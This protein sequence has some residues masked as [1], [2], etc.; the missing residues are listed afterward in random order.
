[1]LIFYGPS[2][3]IL[4]LLYFVHSMLWTIFFFS[5]KICWISNT[6]CR[7]TETLFFSTSQTRICIWGQPSCRYISKIMLNSTSTITTKGGFFCVTVEK[8]IYHLIHLL[9]CV[10]V[11][12]IPNPQYI[13]TWFTWQFLDDS[14]EN[15]FSDLGSF[16]ACFVFELHRN[17]DGVHIPLQCCKRKSKICDNFY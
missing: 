7:R 6:N 3:Q 11:S 15:L 17:P 16:D 10:T 1:M 2:H 12:S 5:A 14:S 13:W 8:H 4:F 9:V